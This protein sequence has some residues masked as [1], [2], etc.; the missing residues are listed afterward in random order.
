M[1]SMMAQAQTHITF[2]TEDYGTLGVYDTWVDS[3]FRTGQLNG[4]VQVVDNHLTDDETNTSAKILG[5]QRSRFGSNTFGAKIN[6]KETFELTPTQRYVHV[7]MHKPVEGK[8]MLIGLGKRADRAEQSNEVE[9]F[10]TYPL[11][12]VKTGEWFDAVFPIKGNGGIDIYSLVIVPHCEAPHTLGDDFVAYVDDIYLDD[13]SIPRVGAGDYTLNFTADTPHGR[14]NERWT[15]KIGLNG[16]ADGNQS[17]NIPTSPNKMAYNQLFDIPFKAKAGETVTAQFGYTSSWMHSYVYIDRDGDGQFSAM[18]DDNLNLNSSCDLMAYTLYSNGASTGKNSAGTSISDANNGFN[19]SITP[20]S[21]TIPSNL[22]NGFYRMRYKVDWNNIDAGGDINSFI[23]NGGI[24]VD[25]MLNVHGDYCNVTNDN[26]NGEVQTATGETLN[27][28]RAAFGQ[29]LKVKMIPSNGFEYSGIRIRHGYNLTGDS[30]VHGNP[31]YRDVIIYADEFDAEDCVTIPAEYMDGDVLIEGLFVEEG[32]GDGRMKV[33]YNVVLDEK[34]ILTKT[35]KVTKGSEWPDHGFTSEASSVYYTLSAKPSEGVVENDTVVVLNLKQ[36]LPFK[37]SVDFANARWHHLAISSSKNYIAHS[38]SS[39]IGIGATTTATPA[40][41][42]ENAQWAFIGDVL[43]GFQ[44]VNKG[45]GEGK[46]LSSNHDT[47]TNTGG[48]TFPVMTA[49]P[50]PST[51]NTYWVPTKSNDISGANGF[52]LHQLGQTSNKLNKRDDKLAYWTGGADAG[53]TLVVTELT[54]YAVTITAPA[55]SH[56]TL[57]VF[58]GEDAVNSGSRVDEGTVLTIVATPNAYY[59]VTEITV[60]GTPIEAV[61]GVYTYT[62][63]TEAITV[64]ASFLRDPNAPIEYCIPEYAGTG[65]SR[66]TTTRTDRYLRNLEVTDG[67]NS[68]TTESYGSTSGRQVYKDETS[69][70][71][72]TTAG[73]TISLTVNASMWAMHNFIYVDFNLDGL[74]SNDRVMYS[75]EAAGTFTFT[76]PANQ[77]PGTYRV[78]HMID[79][80]NTNPCEFAQ[81]QGSDNAEAV[82]DFLLVIE[83]Q[84]LAEPRTVTVISAN[85]ALGTVA[86]TDPATEDSSVS[87]TQKAVTVEATA[88]DDAAFMNWTAN[89]EVV[90]TETT[91]T[92]TGETDIELTANFGYT[93]TYTVGSE[94]NAIFSID[95]AGVTSGDVVAA[96]SMLTITVSPVTGKD[97][98]VT[99]ND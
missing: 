2:D 37:T 86:I 52:Y 76:I 96:G 10:W 43:N 24:I 83:S 31:Q 34:V 56:G 17:I 32:A 3:P 5:V 54:G 88:A 90:S 98:E 21:F 60:N 47:S 69:K 78:R 16:S 22:A 65:S 93:V 28:Y 72:T 64:A 29:P 45:A 27:G 36:N 12:E 51:H 66:T 44:I 35:I 19:V 48:S 58:D 87:T 30:L 91:Y 15:S 33:T 46:I 13:S 81:G 89:G 23:S 92:Y 84:E 67:V 97:A 61:D 55:S 25:V 39:Y 74:D 11:N 75:D 14:A 71:L 94:G 1:T 38:S 41:S 20:P 4:N 63:G 95:G 59:S 7:M 85:E 26:R 68:I 77:A 50:V 73:A 70:I 18:V 80:T 8:V 6:L 9:Q 57:E 99:V 53:S 40:E 42:D 82:T 49:T 62:V 79:W